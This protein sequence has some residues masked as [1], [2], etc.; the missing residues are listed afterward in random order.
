MQK[1]VPG[2]RVQLNERQAPRRPRLRIIA[3]VTEKVNCIMAKQSTDFFQSATVAE[4]VGVHVCRTDRF[5]TISLQL[6]MGRD[7]DERAAYASLLSSVLKQGCRA[8]PDRRAMGAALEKLYG[9]GFS[10][11]VGKVGGRQVFTMRMELPSPKYLPG[12]TDMLGSGVRFLS[13]VLTRP[14]A[15]DGSFPPAAVDREKKNLAAMIRSLLNDKMAYAR[16]RCLEEMCRRERLRFYEHGDVAVLDGITA[17]G[18]YDYYRGFISTAP[19]DVFVVGDVSL[20]EAAGLVAKRLAFPRSGEASFSPSEKVSAPKRPRIVTERQDVEQVKLCIG[21]RTHT[22]LA[23]KDYAAAVVFNGVLGGYSHSRLFRTIREDAGLAYQVDSSLEGSRGLMMISMGI[24]AAGYR[25]ALDIV[26]RQMDEIR[27]GKIT[28]AEM[29]KTRRRLASQLYGIPDSAS[30]LI[31]LWYSQ[32]VNGG[33]QDIERWR[34]RIVAVRVCDV[35]AVARK[36]ETDTIFSLRPG[37][38]G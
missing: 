15:D 13:E 17:K 28:R 11:T 18:L 8:Y 22:V 27:R 9:S 24:D 5:K 1:S 31:S 21:L 25:K 20:K 2:N 37:I 4:G 7:L 32:D 30:R 14:L 12:K 29:S 26:R 34:R 3:D 36:T 33:S 19:M 35:S 23:D 38:S 10:C 16:R 6:W